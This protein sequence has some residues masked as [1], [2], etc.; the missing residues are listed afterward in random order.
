M[1]ITEGWMI[2]VVAFA[3]LGLVAWGM[4][5]IERRISGTPAPSRA[6]QVEEPVEE[7]LEEEY[8][9]DVDAELDE[10]TEV[11]NG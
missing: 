1:H 5:A 6:K 10:E 2:F 11:R 9:E 8:Y 7:E 4:M 3:L